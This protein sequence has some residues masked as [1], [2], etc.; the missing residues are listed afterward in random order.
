MRTGVWL[1][2]IALL[3]L[4]IGCPCGDDD[5]GDDDVTG[6]DDT[7]GDDDAGDDDVTGD[8]DTGPVDE[9]GDGYPADEDC[10]DADP[11]VHP[12]AEEVCDLID[13]DCDGSHDPFDESDADGD[14]DPACGDCD[15]Q[16]AALDSHDADGDGFSSCDGD[17]DDTLSPINPIATDLAGDGIDQNCDGVDGTDSDG[18]GYAS[19]VS[20]G[21]DCDDTNPALN[22]DDVD[23]DGYSTC[24]GDCDDS[25]PLANPGS[26]EICDGLDRDCDGLVDCD[27]PDCTGIPPCYLTLTGSVMTTETYGPDWMYEREQEL[28]G[29]STTPCPGCEYTFEIT[30]NTLAESGTCSIC[31]ALDDGTYTLGFDVDYMFGGYGPYEVILYDIGGAG[32]WTFWSWAYAGQ[33]GHDLAFTYSYEDYGYGFY[34]YG[35]WD[36]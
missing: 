13:N 29:T 23:V 2:L 12:G 31:W 32:N 21:D 27:D 7:T 9:D 8:D 5:T 26:A 15:D 10:D 6:D 20:G 36:F 19:V 22:H 4:S 33:G 24:D 14:G 17:C 35:Y 16:D 18:D 3:S 1:V 30:Y 34:R 25:D 11:N 28:A